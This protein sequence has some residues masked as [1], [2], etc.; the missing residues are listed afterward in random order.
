MASMRM[1]P[2]GAALGHDGVGIPWGR[3]ESMG[4]HSLA[5]RS[6]RGG[7]FWLC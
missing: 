7:T 6:G 4:G 3:L 5:K 1:G 2:C